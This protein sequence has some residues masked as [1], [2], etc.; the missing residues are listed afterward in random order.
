MKRLLTAI[1]LIV[2]ALYLVF[3]APQPV[4]FIAALTMSL[5]C[6]REYAA[7]VVGHRIANPGWVGVAGGLFV[8]L[9]PQL[10][11]PQATLFL[12][13][14][15]LGIVAFIVALRSPDLSEILPYVSCALLGALY[16]F[17]PWRFAIDLR[18]VSVHLLFLRSP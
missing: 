17:A 16:T 14:V 13:L 3:L 12:G 2:L 5:L 10:P 7:L 1:G 8:L 18:N 15:L 9:G 6:Y 11:N 4:F